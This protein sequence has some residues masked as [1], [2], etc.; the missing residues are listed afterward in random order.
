MSSKQDLLDEALERG[1]LTNDQRR[2]LADLEGAAARDNDERIKPVGN[3]NEMFV[4]FGVML[5]SNALGGLIALVF[6]NFTGQ[7]GVQS[8][9]LVGVLAAGVTW[10][11][12]LWFH[13]RKRFRLPIT[14]CVLS[15]AISLASAT[16]IGLSGGIEQDFFSS[17]TPIATALAS[18]VVAILVL[19]IGAARYR[20][21]FLM[22][23]IAILFTTA[24]TYA[25][26]H[27]GGDAVSWRLL[28]GGCGLVI[29]SVAISF[30]LKDP[31]RVT[32]WSDFAFWSYVVGSPLF[33]H[34][35]F[36]SVLLRDGMEE[37]FQSSLLWIAMAAL[38]VAVT[39]AGLLLNRRALIL[40][41]LIYVSIVIF[42]IMTGLSLVGPATMLL[43]TTLIIG[44]YVTALGSRWT[45]VRSTFMKS[46]PPTW[47]W[48]GRLPPF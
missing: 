16:F 32:R 28:L 44:L 11:I 37:W 38:T 24:V 42:R 39:F 41:T 19:G 5:L 34:S 36:L 7:G 4:T 9:V 31:Q 21:P 26:K 8:T 45:R 14:Y 25:A 13:H 1:I 47:K 2:Q 43:L 6:G 46:L 35:L 12:G 3:L 29:L 20:I 40:S 23:P 30:D 27:S 10:S 22:L 17:E 48:V 33:V 18:L 15:A